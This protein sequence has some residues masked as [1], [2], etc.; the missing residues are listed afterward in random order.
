MKGAAVVMRSLTPNARAI[1]SLVARAHMDAD[2]SDAGG[3]AVDA[4]YTMARE[5]FL[6]SSESSL[7]NLCHEPLVAARLQK[8]SCKAHTARES[9]L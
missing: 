9:Q 5:R 4:L 8:G 1:F 3:M 7:E 6:C 2:G